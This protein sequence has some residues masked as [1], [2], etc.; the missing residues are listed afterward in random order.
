MQ[1]WMP[2]KLPRRRSLLDGSRHSL[3]GE[4]PPW[5]GVV[6]GSEKA[7]ARPDQPSYPINCPKE[8]CLSVFEE[9]V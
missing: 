1:P 4:A 3:G 9:E 2:R 6:S 7:V 5:G 8:E